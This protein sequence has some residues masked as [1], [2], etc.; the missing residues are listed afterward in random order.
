L[1]RVGWFLDR[2]WLALYALQ[3]G[4]YLATVTICYV[5]GCRESEKSLQNKPNCDDE[6]FEAVI[7]EKKKE[8]EGLRSEKNNEIRA[9]KN[10]LEVRNILYFMFTLTSQEL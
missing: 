1:L 3:L 7:M 10:E 2:D 8:I 5:I 4:G 9:L 6:K